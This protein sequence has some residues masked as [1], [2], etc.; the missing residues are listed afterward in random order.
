MQCLAIYDLDRTV[1]RRAT[2]T[3]FLLFAACRRAP[4]RLLLLPVWIAAMLMYKLNVFSRGTLK[5]FGLSLFLGSSLTESDLEMLGEAFAD[6][7]VPAWVAPG[8]TRAMARDRKEGYELVL[9]TAAMHFYAVPIG[10]RLCFAE[11]VATPHVRLDRGGRVKISGQNCY[12]AEKIERIN[13]FLAA[14]GARR[15]ECTLRFYSDSINDAPLLGWVD[16]GVLVDANRK[17][18]ARASAEGWEVTRFCR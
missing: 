1:L 2:F 18:K 12:G 7:V 10:R 4:V 8:A 16:R 5:Q 17:G 6:K 15:E 3:P 11:I 14:K 9:A 13:A